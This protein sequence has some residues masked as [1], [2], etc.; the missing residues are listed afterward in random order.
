MNYVHDFI[1][2]N[3]YGLPHD[4]TYV[5][6]VL[7]LDGHE[8]DVNPPSRDHDLWDSI[9][10]RHILLNDHSSKLAVGHL[11]EVSNIV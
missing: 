11:Q 8:Y 7:D 1:Q 5:N 2:E 6:E 10:R 3:C 9:A 4:L